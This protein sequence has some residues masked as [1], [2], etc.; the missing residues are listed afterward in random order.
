MRIPINEKTMLNKRPFEKEVLLI[1]I[2]VIPTPFGIVINEFK[3]LNLN[4]PSIS[5]NY[6][7]TGID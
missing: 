3:L 1:F 7:E 4:V 5:H 6:F 2:T